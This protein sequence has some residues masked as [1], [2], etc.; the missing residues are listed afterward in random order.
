MV[1]IE[2]NFSESMIP[3]F[4]WN[5]AKKHTTSMI[6]SGILAF[7]VWNYLKKHKDNVKESYI[8]RLDFLMLEKKEV[9]ENA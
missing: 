9:E 7:I 6:V 1:T 2:N 4:V 5:F 3:A 8:E